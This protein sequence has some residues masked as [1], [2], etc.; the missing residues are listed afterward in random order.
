MIEKIIP[1]LISGVIGIC[2]GRVW[3]GRNES[4]S[5]RAKFRSFIT[6]LRKKVEFTPTFEVAHAGIANFPRTVKWMPELEREVAE[7]EQHI[8]KNRRIAFADA[9]ST[10][11]S[12]GP[13]VGDE[14]SSVDVKAR[15]VTALNDILKAAK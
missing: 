12:I 6:Q 1:S 7:V 2:I 4:K 5:K 15:L 10:Y 14:K 13:E 3:Q 8:K 9:L 11:R